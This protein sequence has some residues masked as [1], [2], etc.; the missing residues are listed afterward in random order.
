MYLNLTNRK[1]LYLLKPLGWL[2]VIW[3]Y[4]LPIPLKRFEEIS[5]LIYS[6]LTKRNKIL[7]IYTK[8]HPIYENIAYYAPKGVMFVALTSS[9]KK[10]FFST[11]LISKV[12]IF[13]EDGSNSFFLTTDKPIVK[14]FEHP[15][16][17]ERVLNNPQ[18]KNVFLLSQ[19]AKPNLS[20]TEH[21]MEVL[22]PSLPLIPQ[23]R[24]QKVHSQITLLLVGSAASCKGVD[25]VYQAFEK[26]EAKF[27]GKKL[28]LIMASNYKQTVKW[29]PTS[30]KCQGRLHD[31]YKKC[32][33][34]NNVYFSGIY[35]PSLIRLLYKQ[36]DIYVQPSR[37]DSFGFALMEA[38]TYGL[39]VIATT[40][41][42]FP[43]MIEHGRNGFLIDTKDFDLQ[44]EEYFEY[45][46]EEMEKYLTQLIES[47]D[48]RQKMGEESRKI[49]Q[50]KFN[51][52]YQK[53]RLKTIFKEIITHEKPN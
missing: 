47:P 15:Y 2:Y 41:N 21:K 9:L 27:R 53:N 51:L 29:Y 42:A 35:P 28:F 46:V 37:F 43:E 19:W 6:I 25:I 23:Q 8:S 34:K 1:V 52:D 36:V 18:V 39:P 38:I 50:R 14:Y 16:F 13:Y 10:N 17:G 48:L 11:W 30:E 7:V 3:K 49:V 26:V 45:A 31:I 22:Y 12:D 33:K 20:D 24:V 4:K 44:S 5:K 40:I 32:Q